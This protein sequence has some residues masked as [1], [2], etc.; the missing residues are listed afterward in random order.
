MGGGEHLRTKTLSQRCIFLKVNIMVTW[1]PWT[2]SVW[3]LVAP[4]RLQIG[5]ERA[6]M[7]QLTGHVEV[8]FE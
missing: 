7:Q 2:N 4:A 8:L 3:M 1:F 6:T 5:V